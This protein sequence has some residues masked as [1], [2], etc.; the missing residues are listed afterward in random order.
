VG[1][2]GFFAFFSLSHPGSLGTLGLTSPACAIQLPRIRGRLS[3]AGRASNVDS[4]RSVP[5]PVERAD[6]SDL[7]LFLPL[8]LFF[9]LS[10]GMAFGTPVEERLGMRD[11]F[12]KT[13][14]LSSFAPPPERVAISAGR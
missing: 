4:T 13:S 14:Q 7:S 10:I 9:F 8:P 3:G 5:P 11:A 1:P 12:Q 2:P 6:C